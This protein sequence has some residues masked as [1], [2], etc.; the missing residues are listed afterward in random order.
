VANSPGQSTRHGP[1]HAREAP[2][3]PVNARVHMSSW[4]QPWTADLGRG[5][6]LN[7][8][9]AWPPPNSGV[10]ADHESGHLPVAPLGTAPTAATLVAPVAVTHAR[11]PV[12]WTPR[13]LAP[14]CGRDRGALL[15]SPEDG[16]DHRPVHAARFCA[17]ALMSPRASPDREACRQSTGAPVR[18]TPTA[19]TSGC[20]VAA[21]RMLTPRHFRTPAPQ[22]P[23]Y[24]RCEP[25]D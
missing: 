15:A 1:T 6:C 18:L 5:R 24:A 12:T 7:S 11:R 14:T 3:R 23:L 21:R 22:G 25:A 16:K 20:G 10:P 13:R 19:A 8:S 4:T 2:F 17:D 9:R